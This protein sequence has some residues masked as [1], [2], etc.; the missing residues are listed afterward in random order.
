MALKHQTMAMVEYHKAKRLHWDPRD[1]DF[2]R[3]QDDWETL[4]AH[5]RAG[6]LQLCTQFLVGETAVTH[7]LAPLLI[8]MRRRG[9]RLE[10]EIFLATQLYE[11]AKHAEFFDRW[12]TEVAQAEG[13]WDEELTPSYRALFLERLPRVL[14]GCMEEP[15]PLSL[16]LASATYHLIIEGVMAETGYHVFAQGMQRHGL[17]P[18]LMTGVHKVQQDEA[19]HIAYGLSLLR[20]LVQEEPTIW[21]A[22]MASLQEGLMLATGSLSEAFARWGD[23]VPFDLSPNEALSFAARQFSKR[24]AMLEQR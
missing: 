12:L 3:D 23:N 8:G 14:N 18:G 2:T 17:F 15:T 13:S 10:D 21:P 19:R 20:G 24:L 1:L 11:E 16:A 7:D 5:E 22:V 9:G 4:G 6:T